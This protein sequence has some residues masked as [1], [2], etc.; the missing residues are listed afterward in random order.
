MK[1]W[2]ILD[3]IVAHLQELH[4]PLIIDL[5]IQPKHTIKILKIYGK[6]PNIVVDFLF[7][8]ISAK[9]I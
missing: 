7:S 4:H 1:D 8:V 2:I 6:F 9:K 5:I 3:L